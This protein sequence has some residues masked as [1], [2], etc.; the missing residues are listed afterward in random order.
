MNRVPPS[1]SSNPIS[2]SDPGQLQ[3]AHEFFDELLHVAL[4]GG[5]TVLGAARLSA[6]ACGFVQHR[7]RP[8]IDGSPVEMRREKHVGPR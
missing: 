2:S 6:A 8:G 3:P 7:I 1:D 4:P 5:P